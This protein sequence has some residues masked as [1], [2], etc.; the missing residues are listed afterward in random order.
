MP[1]RW[2]LNSI[3]SFFFSLNLLSYIESL[4]V[5]FSLFI[6]LFIYLFIT[7]LTSI[8]HVLNA[9]YIVDI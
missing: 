5:L 9:V 4:W 8:V 1:S 6:Y 3:L 2:F 7:I